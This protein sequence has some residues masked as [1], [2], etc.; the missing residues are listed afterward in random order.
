[1][2]STRWLDKRK[3]HWDRLESLLD[4]TARSGLGSL[5]RM[6]L[7]ELGLL[8]RQ[9][10][11]DLA[12]IR[13]DPTA[14]HF[15]RY[16]NQLLA[17]AHNT[18]YAG[19]RGSALAI[20]AFLTRG[21][22][23]VFRRNL[24]YCLAALAIFAAAGLVGVVLTLSDPDFKVNILG[25]QLVETIQRRQMWTHSIVAVKPQASS[26]I[27]VNNM[28]VAFMSFAMG[29][30]AGL[31]TIYM[32][33]LN[34]LLI[35]VI[36]TACWQAGMSGA[37]WSFVAPHGV[38]ELPAIF[39]AGGAGLRLARGLVFPGTLP[40]KDSVT[41]A[42][43]EAVRLVVGTVPMLVTAGIIEAFVSPTGLSSSLKYSLAAALLVLLTS[44][45][46]ATPA[47]SLDAGAKQGA[48]PSDPVPLLDLQV[49]IDDRR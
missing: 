21:Y 40:R 2:I 11:A 6:E 44:Y 22:P 16:L 41:V 10:A 24:A 14:P 19:Q 25:P 36:G 15:A 33:A 48:W 30:S 17:R 20:V 7:Q 4:T 27:M 49:R 18:I 8:Y 5:T 35:G 29:I 42:G 13:E 45:L 47:R 46:L 28:S 9:A 38:L 34:G 3:P 39:I 37:L 23:A 26:A 31:G 12:V 32:M 43:S 1:V